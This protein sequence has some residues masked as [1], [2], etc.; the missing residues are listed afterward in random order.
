[1]PACV[2]RMT[3]LPCLNFR[4]S[5]S[6]APSPRPAYITCMAQTRSP[7]RINPVL[8]GRLLP[9]PALGVLCA[10]ASC[11]PSRPD[12][13]QRCHS[14]CAP[15]VRMVPCT[16]PT[17]T[18]SPGYYS[19][20]AAISALI[21]DFLSGGDAG[22]PLQ[23][24]PTA[25]PPPQTSGTNATATPR[26]S[27]PMLPGQRKQIVSF[28]AGFDTMYFRLK[29]KDRQPWRYFEV[30]RASIIPHST[31]A[32]RNTCVHAPTPDR[33]P[34]DGAQEMS[35]HQVAQGPCPSLPSPL[36]GLCCSAVGAVGV[37]ARFC[38][39]SLCR[40]PPAGVARGSESRPRGW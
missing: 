33:L 27:L 40:N 20:V 8:H 4:R 36:Q 17:R 37:V 16:H 14:G 5:S 10:A 23:P 9:R 3:M 28:G 2:A 22:A 30:G 7:E 24:T 35:N 34:R 38:F 11:D 25:T 19:R 31:R 32:T 12:Y 39:V 13:Q 1:M 26:C 21:N 15:I 6:V 18:H 29:A